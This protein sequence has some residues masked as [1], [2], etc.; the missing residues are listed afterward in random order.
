MR[1]RSVA[2]AVGLL[3][4]L[5]AL[6]L[7][8]APQSATSIRPVALLAETLPVDRADLLVTGLGAVVGL[9]AVTLAYSLSGDGGAGPLVERPPEAVNARTPSRPGRA[10]DRHIEGD[11]DASDTD[12][13]VREVLREAAIETLVRQDGMQ[14]ENARTAVDRGRWTDDRVA[15][16]F[17]G[18]P[19]QPLGAR[20]RRWLDPDRER[21]RRANRTIEAIERGQQ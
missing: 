18:A 14:P 2:G 7:V 9:V 21:R 15:A 19:A 13:R 17:L 6:G 12:E 8:A 3:G 11:L 10:F 20:L 16:A 1:V 4:A 5:L